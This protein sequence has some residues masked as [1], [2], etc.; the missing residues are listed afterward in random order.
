MR[1]SEKFGGAERLGM[2]VGRVELS[3]DLPS[4]DFFQGNLLLDV[5]EHH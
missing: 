2:H 4:L 5:F 3:I 1:H